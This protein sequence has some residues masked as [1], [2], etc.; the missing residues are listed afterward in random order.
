MRGCARGRRRSGNKRGARA[1]ILA[2]QRGC[3]AASRESAAHGGCASSATRG[4]EA[5]G[6][7]ADRSILGDRCDLVPHTAAA[8]AG[9]T[10]AC[11]AERRA[12]DD[13]S[14]VAE[15]KSA[16][17]GRKTR[18]RRYA[19]CRRCFRERRLRRR[20][21]GAGRLL[22]C[23]DR[24]PIQ[25]PWRCCGAA[26]PRGSR[27]KRPVSMPDYGN[28]SAARIRARSL[29]RAEPESSDLAVSLDPIEARR[30]QNPPLSYRRG[31]TRKPGTAERWQAPRR[32]AAFATWATAGWRSRATARNSSEIGR[33]EGFAEARLVGSWG[34]RG[35][36][37]NACWRPQAAA[38]GRVTSAGARI[39]VRLAPGRQEPSSRAVR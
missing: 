20:R 39:G 8:R 14:A 23:L 9:T 26:C 36:G 34:R 22:R 25:S 18:R 17:V 13:V 27:E 33:R 10:R 32:L 15:G 2:A 19:P 6:G 3:S 7:H 37:E 5:A 21:R 38:A 28:L 30:E 1:F 4:G 12:C 11:R 29:V 24:R 35:R 31:D 16:K